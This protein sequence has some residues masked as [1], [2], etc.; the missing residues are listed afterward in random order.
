MIQYE[1]S[2]PGKECLGWVRKVF[3]RDLFT[4]LICGLEILETVMIL[5]VCVCVYG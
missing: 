2:K 5:Y 4:N 1:M 3:V